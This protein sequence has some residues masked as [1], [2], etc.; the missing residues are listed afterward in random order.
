MRSACCTACARTAARSP[1]KRRISLC[2]WPATCQPNHTVPIGLS[3]E[4]P[5]SPALPVTARLIW[6]ALYRAAHSAIEAPVK[7]PPGRGRNDPCGC[8]KKYKICRA[9]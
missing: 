9:V 8:G 4:P 2:V 3:A 5:L 6:A 1:A 7:R